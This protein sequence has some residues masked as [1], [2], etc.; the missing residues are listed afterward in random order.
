M[1]RSGEEKASMFLDLQGFQPSRG[2]G[3]MQGG[4][5]AGELSLTVQRNPYTPREARLASLYMG[6][7][8]GYEMVE[9][10]KT[11]APSPHCVV[12]GLR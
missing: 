9:D 5:G 3:Q 11:Q 1:S 6:V 2:T 8:V 7:G 12:L 10:Q 4:A